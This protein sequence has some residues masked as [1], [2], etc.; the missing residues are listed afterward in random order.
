[1]I[2]QC[3]LLSLV[4]SHF[5]IPSLWW[6]SN[7]I[8]NRYWCVPMC[9]PSWTG[10]GQMV[11]EEITHGNRTQRIHPANVSINIYTAWRI[12][13]TSSF[14]IIWENFYYIF[15]V[16][17]QDVACCHVKYYWSNKD[18]GSVTNKLHHWAG[19]LRNREIS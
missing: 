5:V 9:I 4:C 1:M 16:I 10:M 3:L 7:I 19:Q 14:N 6:L 17:R 15:D 18:I 8:S 12:N 11:Q 13:N 2:E